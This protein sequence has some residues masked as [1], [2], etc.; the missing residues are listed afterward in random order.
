LAA[1]VIPAGPGNTDAQ[2]ELIEAYRPIGYCGTPDFLKILIDASV[3]ADR[4]V[5]SIKRAAVSGAAFSAVAAKGDQIARHR[6]LSVVRKP[7]TSD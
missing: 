7:P 1:A 3:A 5:S 6:G 2:F 4:D